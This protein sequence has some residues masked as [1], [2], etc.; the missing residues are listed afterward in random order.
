MPPGRF[1][2]LRHALGYGGVIVEPATLGGTGQFDRDHRAPAHSTG[3]V[4][5]PRYYRRDG[6]RGHRPKHKLLEDAI[7]IQSQPLIEMPITP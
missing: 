2:C 6:L 4:G 1:D 7:E 3:Q 5:G